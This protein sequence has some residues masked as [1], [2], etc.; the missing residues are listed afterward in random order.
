MITWRGAPQMTGQA[1]GALKVDAR[2][3]L[4]CA[5]NA[6]VHANYANG[7]AVML[8]WRRCDTAFRVTWCRRF[9]GRVRR[10]NDK[11]DKAGLRL[12]A[13]RVGL[14]ILNWRQG[15]RTCFSARSLH[16]SR[17]VVSQIPPPRSASE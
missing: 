11:N 16:F 3:A 12:R 6:I 14:K 17:D 1:S 9:L 13:R 8:A 15:G 5:K 7:C 10:R 2:R 4:R